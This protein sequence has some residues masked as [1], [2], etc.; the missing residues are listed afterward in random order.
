MHPQQRRSSEHTVQPGFCSAAIYHNHFMAE[1]GEALGHMIEGY[2]AAANLPR[3]NTLGRK[4]EMPTGEEVDAHS[5]ILSGMI[6]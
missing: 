2:L 6:A 1:C 3:V 4:W 5:P